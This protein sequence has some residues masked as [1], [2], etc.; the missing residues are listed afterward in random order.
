MSKMS[1][2]TFGAGCFWCTEACFDELN[3]VHK[4][5]PGFSGG[6]R[7]N[8]SY[9]QVCSGA[10][11]HAEVAQI[12]FDEDV[13]SFQE[14]LR[15]FWFIHDPTQLN[16]Q[17]NDIG[18]H[19]RSVVFYHNERQAELAKQFKSRL[20]EQKVWDAPIVT[21]ISPFDRFYAAENYHKDYLKNNPSNMYC[22]AVVRPKIEKFKLA[23][24]G[25]LK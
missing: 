4:V 20:T 21:E 22:Q 6:K 1:I 10:T 7:E 9:E 2:A 18:T 13:I 3:G 19:Y 14:L 25:L 17:G 23:F 24:V 15:V 11:G 8:P 5:V 16:R 12:T